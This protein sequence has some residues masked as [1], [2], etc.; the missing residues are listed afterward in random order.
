MWS[1]AAP[2]S[3]QSTHSSRPIRFGPLHI[4]CLKR[5]LRITKR[6]DPHTSNLPLRARTLKDQPFLNTSATVARPL[7]KFPAFYRTQDGSLQGSQKLSIS[8]HP[9][10]DKSICDSRL[11]GRVL[12]RSLSFRI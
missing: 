6:R 2:P 3:F 10:T 1:F 8:P 11:P 7:Q 5:L 4:S 12:R 9:K